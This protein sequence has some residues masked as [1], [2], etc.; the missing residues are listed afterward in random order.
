MN[1]DLV[2]MK[3]DGTNKLVPLTPQQVKAGKGILDGTTAK[4]KMLPEQVAWFEADTTWVQYKDR[5]MPCIMRKTDEAVYSVLKDMRYYDP[6]AT[7]T[8]DDI[9]TVTVTEANTLAQALGLTITTDKRA[10]GQQY[11]SSARGDYSRY[12]RLKVV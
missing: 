4:I 7:G 8:D 1:I 11:V 10:D 6:A 3:T 5:F 9:I 2:Y 12:K